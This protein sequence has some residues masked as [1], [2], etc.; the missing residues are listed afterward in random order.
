M[1]LLENLRLYTGEEV[2]LDGAVLVEG[3]KILYAGARGQC[4]PAQGAKR[5]DGRGGIL[6]PGFYNAHCHGAMTLVRGV[7]SD[8]NLMDWLHKIWPIEDGLTPEIVYWGT[9][10][11]TMEMLRRGTVGYGDMYFFE[12]T[13]GQAALD[14]GI[15]VNLARG[16][17]EK[18][19]VDSVEGMY[20]DWHGQGRGRVRVSMGVH[21]EYTSTPEVVAYAVEKGR[22]LGAGFHVHVA[23]TKSETEGCIQRHGVTPVK[24]FYDLG[25]FDSPTLAAHCV[26]VTDEDMDLMAEK[27]V[28]AVHNPASNM[29]LASG[30]APVT[31]MLKKGVKVALGTDGA[32][33]NNRLDMLSDMRLASILQKGRTGDPTALPAAQAFLM[34]TRTG[35]LAMGW[36]DCGLLKEDMQADMVLLDGQ[37]ENLCPAPDLP[38]AIVYAAQ[39]LNVRMTMVQGKVLYQDGQFTTLDA[40]EVVRKAEEAARKLGVY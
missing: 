27:G 35:A 19:E 1:V 16:C 6:M 9:Q 31:K 26:H 22:A 14:S 34:A 3:E 24:Y 10:Q 38:A 30:F 29:K 23:E 4:P 25:M 39:G 21:G 37:A 7:G 15:R 40:Q 17:M 28:Y 32:S 20:R 12:E 18:D 13:V 11:A 8:L 33:S 5:V 36:Q 2:F